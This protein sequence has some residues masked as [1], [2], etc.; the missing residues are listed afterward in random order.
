[1]RARRAIVYAVPWWEPKNQ[2]PQSTILQLRKSL[3][4][5]GAYPRLPLLLQRTHVPW[6][7]AAHSVVRSKT[8]CGKN[9]RAIPELAVF[10]VVFVL[11]RLLCGFTPS[12]F[13][14]N[15]TCEPREALCLPGESPEEAL[16]RWLFRFTMSP[17]W[18]CCNTTL[19][20]LLPSRASLRSASPSQLSSATCGVILPGQA[21]TAIPTIKAPHRLDVEVPV[22]S[23]SLHD[24]QPVSRRK[25][26]QSASCPAMWR[27]DIQAL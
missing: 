26:Q 20:E 12:R 7:T 13:A 4:R 21:V 5:P 9:Q 22:K 3:Q 24:A 17:F 27:P 1:M 25:P 10:K 8:S 16:A 2:R 18:S 23:G 6:H 11:F 19:I 14:R 15:F